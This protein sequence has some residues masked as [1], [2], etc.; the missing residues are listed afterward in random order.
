MHRQAP[1]HARRQRLAPA[2][3]FAGQVQRRDVPGRPG[4][5]IEGAAILGRILAGLAGQLIDGVLHRHGG[6]GRAHRAPP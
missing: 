2:G 1:R 3:L 6:V 4:A 5:G